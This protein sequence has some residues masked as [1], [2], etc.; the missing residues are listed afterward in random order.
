MNHLV[1]YT[2]ITESHYSY[3]NFSSK[4]QVTKSSN[5]PLSPVKGW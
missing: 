1:T 2:L 5:N 4:N 3:L